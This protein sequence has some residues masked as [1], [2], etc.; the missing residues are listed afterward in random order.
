MS[1][2]LNLLYNRF[3][4]RY[5]R[6]IFI[7]LLVVL[8][9]YIGYNVYQKVYEKKAD[10]KEFSDVANTNTRK[11]EAQVLFFFANWCPHC[12]KATPEWQQFKEEYNNNK[13]VNEYRISCQEID[14]TDEKDQKT[15][16]LIKQ[17]NIESYP[18]IIMLVGDNK[19][20]YDAKVTKTGLEQ[21]VLSGTSR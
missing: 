3:L 21:L 19:I 12:R 4:S 2:I 8:F 6:I 11:K 13:V 16:A 18:T 17:Y 1:G 15:A 14:C 9:S 7:V 5:S 10:I 20:D